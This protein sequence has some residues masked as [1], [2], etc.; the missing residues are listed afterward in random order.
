MNKDFDFVSEF[1][2]VYTKYKDTKCTLKESILEILEPYAIN[3]NIYKHLIEL[4]PE[5]KISMIDPLNNASHSKNN[6]V[7]QIYGFG[8][9]NTLINNQIAKAQKNKNSCKHCG[10]TETI[11]NI[12]VGSISCAGCGYSLGKIIYNGPESRSGNSGEDQKGEIISRCTQTSNSH[13]SNKNESS[14]L[15]GF[16]NNKSKKKQFINMNN[17]LNKQMNIE[18]SLKLISELS[19]KLNLTNDIINFARE[20]YII[21]TKSYTKEGIKTNPKTLREQNNKSMCAI[22][23]H[24][25]ANLKKWPIGRKAVSS[26]FGVDKKSLNK[27][28]KYL[29]EVINNTPELKP[30]NKNDQND[31]QTYIIYNCKSLD[32]DFRFENECLRICRNA[33]RCTLVVGHNPPSIS[34]GIIA[35]VCEKYELNIK[36]KDIALSHER[37]EATLSK[38]QQKIIDHYEMLNNDKLTEYI[39]NKYKI[40]YEKND[41]LISS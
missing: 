26:A 12:D 5:I 32:I 35:A 33:I 13:F 9:D 18:K 23:V 39:M 25:A 34:A 7:G 14:L 37:S 16:V 22:C 3:M 21:S 27:P 31:T 8:Y 24:K 28:S 36:K 1:N 38:V 19:K 6:N 30:I 4:Y 29:D 11:E 15:F 40:Y 10:C 2:Y 41:S 20:L 17:N